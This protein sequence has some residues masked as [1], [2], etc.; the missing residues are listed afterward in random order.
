VSGPATTLVAQI[1]SY[2]DVWVAPATPDIAVYAD[3][4]VYTPGWRTPGAERARYVVRRLTPEGLAAVRAEF[5]RTV[6]PGGDVGTAPEAGLGSGVAVYTVSTR[7]DGDLVTATTTSDRQGPAAEALRAFVDRW[8]DPRTA[9]PSLTWVLPQ[10]V[11]YEAAT[12]AV[13]F[14]I[15][16]E[17]CRDPALP[18][19]IT[20]IEPVLGPVLRF[21]RA[22][23]GDPAA[24]CGHVDA[25]GQRA[26]MALLAVNG[27]PRAGALDRVDVD[28]NLGRGVST[29]AVVPLLPGTD[30]CSDDAG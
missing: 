9:M 11:P 10:P 15:S 20:A 25:A 1:V 26:L 14:W 17:C 2:A 19:A 16:D 18:D 29:M 21:G 30:G 24:R 22:R 13:Y 6:G 7:R 3:G 28:V 5:D 4:S 27:E 12:F 23:P 8:Q